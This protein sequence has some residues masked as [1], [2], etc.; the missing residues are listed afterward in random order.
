MDSRKVEFKLGRQ[1]KAP[2]TAGSILY[3]QKFVTAGLKTDRLFVHDF[4]NA[5][6]TYFKGE[7]SL[8]SSYL[9]ILSKQC[10]M[11]LGRA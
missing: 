2:D 3:C 1:F 4:P 11:K 10:E 6:L 9:T 5:L 7:P 8:G